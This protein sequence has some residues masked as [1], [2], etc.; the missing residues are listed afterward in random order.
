MTKE[1]EKGN[2]KNPQ[3]F[4]IS[5]RVSLPQNASPSPFTPKAMN[6]EDH[7]HIL[8]QVAISINSNL[9]VLLIGETG[10]GKTSLIRY[11]A[12]KTGHGFRRVNHNGATTTDDIVGKLLLNE[13]GTF[14][15]DGALVDAMRKG[16]WYLADEINAAPAEVNFAYH[17][18]LDDDGYLV[19]SEHNGEIVRPHPSF[20]FFAAMNPSS[21]Y[22]GTK[23]LNKALLSRFLVI[24][25]DFPAPKVEEAIL[26]NRTGISA[27]QAKKLVSFA[28]EVRINHAKGKTNF[29]VS[30]RDLLMWAKMLTI[31]GKYI[32]SAEI[33]VLNKVGE[34][35]FESIKD[36]LGLH[37]KNLDTGKQE[38]TRETNTENK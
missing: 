17:S 37:F 28:A 11:L 32:V 36:L 29:V 13:K 33:S 12:A 7:K 38:Q 25:T 27:E 20:R 19:L 26:K 18:L 31:Y 14:W 3:S 23:E 10:S 22:A 15:V 35:D 9:P 8:E 2:G 16:D 6:F 21:D 34:D 5:P 30:T 24:K 1:P 4:R